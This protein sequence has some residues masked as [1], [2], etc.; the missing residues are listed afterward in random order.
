MR[1]IDLHCDTLMLLVED[2]RYPLH[3]NF[4]HI[5]LKRLAKGGVAAQC[6][7]IFLPQ[8]D[9]ITDT[10]RKNFKL[11]KKEYR[12]FKKQMQTYSGLI[13]Q[14]LT[15]KEITDN[16][17][18][19]KI[20]AILTVE[21]GDF[22]GK[23]LSRLSRLSNMGVRMMGLVW[24][25]ENSLAY[26]N[27]IDD[28]HNL[29][30]KPLGLKAVE[31]LNEMGIIIDVSHLNYGGFWDVARLSK[32]PFVASHSCCDA[33]FHHPRNL[34]DEQ[35][36]AIAESGGTVGINFFT[37]F[38]KPS[39]SATFTADIVAQAKHIKKV[40]GIEAVSFGSDFDGMDS[41]MEFRDC[42]GYPLIVEELLKEFTFD[43]CEKICYKNALR[44]L[45]D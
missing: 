43:E 6:F 37:D 16:M 2:K 32:K 26:P 14:A 41:L 7:A 20:S 23:D 30:L 29:H 3:E 13:S 24:N 38:I 5:D 15:A 34:D 33:L 22:I 42:A 1:I 19:N 11:L 28:T 9:N 27:A 21:N 44:V 17:R 45:G 40:A 8:D 36:K 10:S 12:L 4:G 18:E 39:P 35:L 31:K 25:F